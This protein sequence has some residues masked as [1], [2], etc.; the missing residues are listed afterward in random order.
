MT[1]HDKNKA[2]FIRHFLSALAVL[3]KGG[4]QI[5]GE[6]NAIMTIVNDG[7]GE[8][9]QDGFQGLF[10][11]MAQQGRAFGFRMFILRPF[12]FP[13]IRSRLSAKRTV[14]RL[15][16]LGFAPERANLVVCNIVSFK[17]SPRG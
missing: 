13:K 12:F 16:N 15:V 10:C 1:N 14:K 5:I 11:G 4:V 3:K 2:V 9:T 7:R 8:F 6:E 17:K